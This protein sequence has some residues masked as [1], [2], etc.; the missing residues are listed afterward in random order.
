MLLSKEISKSVWNQISASQSIVIISHMRPDG[1]AVGSV[2]GL[3]IFLIEQGKSV[4]MVLSDGV[5]SSLKFLTGSNLIQ[6]RIK[7][8][9]DLLIILDSSDIHRMSMGE[10]LTGKPDINIDHHI[11]NELYARMNIVF[12]EAVSTTEIIAQIIL[13]NGMT[14][15]TQVA[16]NLLT[17]IITDTIGFRTTNMKSNALRLSADLV[18]AGAN[19]PELY[20]K[21]LNHKSFEAIKFWGS[22]LSRLERDKEV[23][24]SKLTIADR[25]LAGYPGRDDADLINVLSTIDDALVVILFVEQANGMIKISWRSVPGYDVT[26]VASRYGGGGHPAASGAEVSG[27][28]DLICQEVVQ[29]TKKMLAL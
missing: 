20:L 23:I 24:W 29:V 4:Q 15:S 19:L 13:Q 28:L 14:F 26:K 2:L 6:Q 3:G 9:F 18:D 17:G 16:E 25:N 12:P 1:D 11:T 8:Q 22:G 7:G 27:K 10:E 5:P 21:A